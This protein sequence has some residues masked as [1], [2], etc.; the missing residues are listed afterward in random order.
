MLNWVTLCAAECTTVVSHPVSTLQ[1]VLL[2]WVKHCIVC[3]CA[4]GFMVGKKAEAGGIAKDGAKMV[5]A[6]ANV[7]VCLGPASACA[8]SATL[9]H[10]LLLL[11]DT[12]SASIECR[13]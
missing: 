8:P 5:M 7:K 6:V 10:F 9:Q 13:W 4:A 3:W 2:D 11:D 1:H 12:T